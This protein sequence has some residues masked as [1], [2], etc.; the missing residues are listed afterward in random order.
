M[1]LSDE[2]DVGFASL[3]LSHTENAEESAWETGAIFPCCVYSKTLTKRV[4]STKTCILHG[5][6]ELWKTHLPSPFIN[7]SKM[8]NICGVVDISRNVAKWWVISVPYR[9]T[10][11]LHIKLPYLEIMQFQN[12]FAK[13]VGNNS[14]RNSEK[15]CFIKKNVIKLLTSQI[16]KKKP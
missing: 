9:H 7:I 11:L 5:V 6:V 12:S 15:I 14:S 10:L 4:K 8:H 3:V 1:Y 13:K 16:I 2:Q